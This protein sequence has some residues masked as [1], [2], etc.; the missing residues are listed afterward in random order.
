MSVAG[1]GATIKYNYNSGSEQW[2]FN[3]APY[4]NTDRLHTTADEGSGNGIDADTLDGQEGTYYLNYNNF[5]GIATDSDKLDGQ[6]GTYY[7]NYSNFSGIATDSDKLDGQQGTYYLDYA[8]FSGIATDSD[9]LDGQ[10]GTYYLDYANFS[11]IATDSDK[12]DGQQGTY[13]LNYNNF[14]GIATDSDKLDGQEGTYYLNY[15]NFVG[16]AT[17]SDKLDGQDGSYYL[18]TSSTGQTKTGDLTLSKDGTANLVVQT[19]KNSGADALIKIRG[20]RTSCNTCDI[21]MLQFDN[22]PVMHTLWHR[23]LPWI[24]LVPMPMEKVS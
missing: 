17:D 22:R 14:V 1:A 11:G 12:L 7:L 3:K 9:K 8:N 13:Y 10:Q 15:N 2:V 6:Q 20:A 16:I 18:D 21:A 4:Y 24:Q 19:S 23:F 5:V